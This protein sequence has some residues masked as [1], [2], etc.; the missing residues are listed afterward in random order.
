MQFKKHLEAYEE[1]RESDM[2]LQDKLNYVLGQYISFSFNDP[3]K[4]PKKPYFDE[5]DKKK[6]EVMSEDEMEEV[7]KRNTLMMGGIIKK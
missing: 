2:K 7:I 3:K 6:K 1:K 4:Y 5:L